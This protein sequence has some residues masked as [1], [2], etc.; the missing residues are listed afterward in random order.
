[1]S[2]Y[3]IVIP[4]RYA[5]SRLPG[6]P[7]ID[8]AGKPMI[9][10][11]YERALEA[12]AE[13]VVVATD[14]DRIADVA[15]GFG[16]DVV[17]TSPDHENGTERIAEVVSV[18]GW[19][20]DTVVVNLQGDEPL[21][22]KSLIELTAEGLLQ[23]SDAGMSSVCTP[24]TTAHDAF[25]PNVV[26]VVLNERHF[27]MYFSR[28]PI[29]WD[30]DLYKESQEEVTARMPVYRHIGMYGY[31][32]S[33]LNDYREMAPCPIELTESLEQLRALWYGVNIHMSVID[34]APGH[35]IDTPHDVERVAAIL[36]AGHHN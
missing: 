5:S 28:A 26:K 12:G 21:I 27:A 9:Q 1:M 31:R 8:L 6:K 18:K 36:K 34:Q 3:K 22:P 14:D 10:H 24:I 17:M 29:P 30:R 33:F 23:N 20:A 7:L 32:V 16:A 15:R 11:V 19:S 25:D 2:G 13:D 35:G 4:A